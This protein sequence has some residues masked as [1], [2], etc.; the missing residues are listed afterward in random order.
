[1]PLDGLT[2]G[3]LARE[4]Q[5]LV[6]GRI[7]RVSQPEKDMAVLLIRAEGKNRRLLKPPQKPAE[8]A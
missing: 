7:D 5:G 1:M 8:K 2:M 3:F 4:M 6:G